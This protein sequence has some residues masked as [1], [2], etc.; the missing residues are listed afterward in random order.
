M[1]AGGVVGDGNAVD[2]P[3]SVESALAQLAIGDGEG[4]AL[5]VKLGAELT[6]QTLGRWASTIGASSC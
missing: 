6:R 2:A 1:L 4:V 5:D 3:A